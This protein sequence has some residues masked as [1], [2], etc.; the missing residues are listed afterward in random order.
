MI[1][2]AATGNAYGLRCLKSTVMPITV[3]NAAAMLKV[4]T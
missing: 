2:N 1:G 4:R 3:L